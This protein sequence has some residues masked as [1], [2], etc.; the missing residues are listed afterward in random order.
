MGKSPPWMRLYWKDLLGSCSSMTPEVFGCYV[1]LLGEQ[2]EHG[3]IPS[4]MDE[5][6][7]V[8]LCMS[9]D[10]FAAIW[11]K[12]RHRFSVDDDGNLFQE[13]LEE[14]RDETI[15]HLDR[16]LR[17]SAI[18]RE[19]GAKGGRPKNPRVNPR[20]SKTKPMGSKNKTQHGSG[21]RSIEEVEDPKEKTRPT[22]PKRMEGQL[23]KDLR[24]D[25]THLT[26]Q[27]ER[28]K[29]PKIKE[30]VISW[31]TY[32]AER[33]E[34]YKSQGL[35]AYVSRVLGLSSHLGES[36]IISAME[37][38][39]ANGWTGFDHDLQN[40][41]QKPESQESETADSSTWEG[42]RWLG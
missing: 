42:I 17:R 9:P 24:I 4:T 5:R 39:M 31:L 11:E 6:Q 13:R 36:T 33:R 29:S 2:W 8:C 28:I 12:L 41:N 20:V 34:H 16:D 14:V 21:S 7:M 22:D 19:N 18:A 27:L 10:R 25:S 30:S 40:N 15:E 32:K 37:R 1:R 35:K 26:E 23:A 38:A 3:H